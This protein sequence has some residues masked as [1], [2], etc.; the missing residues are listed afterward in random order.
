M[1]VGLGVD[2]VE[3][4]RIRKALE[5]QPAMIRRVFT[6]SEAKYCTGRKNPY[7]HFAGRFAAKEAALKALGTGWSEGIRW[8]DVEIS[9]E[10]S[11]KPLLHF[12]GRAH[13]VFDS[14]DA[15]T[16]FLTITHARAY[17]VAVVVLDRHR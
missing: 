14:L 12:H 17:A 7:Q 16:I 8:R 15:S 2:I 6:G 9:S 4:E 5:D 13:E 11:G 3:V 1:V 10:P